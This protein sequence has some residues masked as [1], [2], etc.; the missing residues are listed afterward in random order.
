MSDIDTLLRERRLDV[1]DFQ[2]QIE[3][4]LESARKGLLATARAELNGAL[5]ILDKMEKRAR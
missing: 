4:A 2:I 5:L 1:E 3:A